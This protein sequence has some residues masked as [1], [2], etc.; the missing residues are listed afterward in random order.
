MDRIN[1]QHYTCDH[2]R[3]L[4]KSIPY[5]QALH[6]K[7]F[8]TKVLE[9]FKNLPVLKESFRNVGF[10]EK[11]LDTELQRLSEI[12][13]NAL[14]APKS[15]EKDQNRILFLERNIAYQVNK[16]LVDLIESKKILNGKVVL[17]NNNKKQHY[18]RPRFTRGDDICCQQILKTNTFSFIS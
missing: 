10:N 8:C 16:N 3:S 7:K 4:I 6:L 1:F 2:P 14:L 15:K 11:I 17:K 5:S 13:G 18:C 9:P 12:E